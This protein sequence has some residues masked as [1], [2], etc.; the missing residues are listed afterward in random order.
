MM[1]RALIHNGAKEVFILGRRLDVLQASS[2]ANPGLTPVQCDITSKASLQSA[3]D[4]ISSSTGY[5]NLVVANSGIGGTSAR[6]SSNPTVTSITELRRQ[7]FTDHSMDEFTNTFAVNV[8]GAF[9][10]MM[11]FLELLDQGNQNSLSE[12]HG[13]LSEPGGAVPAVQSQI[14]VTSSISAYIRGSMTPPS[15]GASKAAVLHL[16]KQ[17]S[18][19]LAGYGVR[20]NALAPGCK[21]FFS[22]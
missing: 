21:P 17:A 20:V 22:G 7:L 5:L 11:A 15:Y 18:S 8:S 10:T 14:V 3:V 9:F 4:T 12:G 6:Y 13:S 19:Q 16:A 2:R 1:A